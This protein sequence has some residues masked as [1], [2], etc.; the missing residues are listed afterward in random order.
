VYYLVN[1]FGLGYFDVMQ[2][3]VSRR[4]RMAERRD[5]ENRQ[6]A[7]QQ[8]AQSKVGGGAKKGRRRR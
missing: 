1:E 7:A 5:L 4:Y 8:N 3:P 2:M 6:A